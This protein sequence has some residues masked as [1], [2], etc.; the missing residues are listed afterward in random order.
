MAHHVVRRVLAH[1]VVAA[2]GAGGV[3]AEPVPTEAAEDAETYLELERIQQMMDKRGNIEEEQ[4][5]WSKARWA[6]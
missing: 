2:K 4:V 1:V 6:K 3:E 5:R